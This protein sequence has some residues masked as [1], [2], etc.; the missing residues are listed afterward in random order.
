MT[1]EKTIPALRHPLLRWFDPHMGERNA[2]FARWVWVRALALIY[3]S[4]FYS[5]LFQ[6][7]GLIGPQ[8]IEPAGAYLRA[9]AQYYGHSCYWRAPTLFWFSSTSTA[10]MT[11]TWIGIGA[12][13]LAFCNLWPR[14]SL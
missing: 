8:G 10:V 13:I 7:K 9:A 2:V 1:M 12:S 5:L 3:F 6:I 4:A 11:V 14:L